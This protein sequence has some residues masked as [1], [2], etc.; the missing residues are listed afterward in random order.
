M[1]N[2]THTVLDLFGFSC[3]GI[4]NMITLVILALFSAAWTFFKRRHLNELASAKTSLASTPVTSE[5]LE[6][7]LKNIQKTS[8][9]NEQPPVE[10]IGP[11][12]S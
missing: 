9:Q 3:G 10:H 1:N 7:I 4:V 5:L 8:N 12:K 6:L 11:D 2:S